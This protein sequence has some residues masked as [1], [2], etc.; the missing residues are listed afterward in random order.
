MAFWNYSVP[1]NAAKDF[2]I[3]FSIDGS[4]FFN[5]VLGMVPQL[6]GPSHI[7]DLGGTYRADMVRVTFTDNYFGQGAGGDR[8]GLSEIRFL[9]SQVVP[10]PATAGLAL[11]GVLALCR[12]RRAA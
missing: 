7:F 3:E 10:E 1:G 5:P 8:V 12:R 4:P 6:A 2:T 11:I 9:G